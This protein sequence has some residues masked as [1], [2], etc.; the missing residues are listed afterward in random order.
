M[1]LEWAMAIS[2]VVTTLNNAETIRACLQ[3]LK[4][5]CTEII[6]LDSGSTD[7]TQLIANEFGARWFVQPFS[8]YAAQK[9]AA[10]AKA[11]HD[12]IVLLD[13]DEALDEK[14]QAAIGKALATANPDALGYAIDRSELV[15][16]QFQHRLSHHNTFVR[17]FHRKSARVSALAVHESVQVNGTIK[18]LNGKIIHLG[19]RSIDS[20]VDKL[21]RYST[22]AVRDK[23][24][25]SH[26]SLALRTTL[27]PVW[28]LFRSYVLRRQFLNGM[29]GWINS[30]ELAHYAFL[31]YAKLYERK[32]KET[33]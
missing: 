17:V 21:N 6:V 28:Y 8:G 1:L 15:F 5:I 11:S 25:R 23:K 18:R 31:K 4:A 20:K 19:D 12:W 22:L 13:S 30:V 16:W 26:L 27:Y 32:K 3:S 9:T 2:G 33:P 10:I 14:A 29:A 7:A 24:P